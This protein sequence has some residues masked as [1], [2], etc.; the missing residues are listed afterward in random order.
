MGAGPLPDEATLLAVAGMVGGYT[1]TTGSGGWI[2]G[3]GSLVA[4]PAWQVTILGPHEMVDRAVKVVT[5]YAIGQGESAV[6]AA[7]DTV[8]VD[9]VTEA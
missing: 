3:G 5:G 7:R 6:L 2:D 8:R 4:E 9:I 1:L